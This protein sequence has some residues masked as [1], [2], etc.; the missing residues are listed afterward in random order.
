[1]AQL[2][3]QP[4]PLENRLFSSP[5]QRQNRTLSP[6]AFPPRGSWQGILGH[7][8][9]NHG[10]SSLPR[11]EV[12][13]V[14]AGI[15]SFIHLHKETPR[16]SP[17]EFHPCGQ[18]PAPPT[19]TPSRRCQALDFLSHLLCSTVGERIHVS[20]VTGTKQAQK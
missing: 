15:L 2:A 13:Q 19:F 12:L 11:P 3:E 16:A 4:S 18:S 6:H 7:V 1:M 17:S 14:L 9:L 10:P 20:R 8:G 5:A